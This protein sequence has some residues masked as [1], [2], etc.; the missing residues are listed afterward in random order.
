[1]ETSRSNAPSYLAWSI[2]NTFCCC[3]PLGI[4]AIIFSTRVNSA[5]IA[6]DQARAESDSRTTKYLNIAALVCGIIFLTIF[7]LFTIMGI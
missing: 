1:M 3:L 6:G 4:A 5:N 2:F 7:I